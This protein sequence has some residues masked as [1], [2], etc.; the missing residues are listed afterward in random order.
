MSNFTWRSTCEEVIA[1]LPD[2]VAEVAQSTVIITGTTA[3]I[4]KY[5]ARAVASTGATV[6]LANRSPDKA[7]V[8]AAEVKEAVP[9]ATIHCLALDLSSLASVEAFVADFESRGL[10]PLKVLILNAALMPP[11]YQ[12]SAEGY[13]LTWATNHLGHQHLATLL[14]PRLKAA[15][16]SRVVVVSS[17]SLLGPLSTKKWDSRE[18]LMSKIIQPPEDHWG[19]ATGLQHYGD[20]KLANALFAFQLHKLYHAEG[21]A[22]CSLHPG[23]MMATDLARESTILSVLMKYILKPFTKSMSQGASTTLL[24]ALMPHDK[25]QG[26]FFSDCQEKSIS[27]IATNPEVAELH[28]QLSQE[29]AVSVP[30][31]TPRL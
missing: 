11:A 22:A 7:A 4:G 1:S 18:E 6:V 19:A 5:T 16:P 25:L 28:W 2:G 26:L 29:L 8:A 23:T 27:R 3:G 21:V 15:A 9:G 12:K 13:E 24:C 10:P 17:L 31:P 30:A 20:S 14:L